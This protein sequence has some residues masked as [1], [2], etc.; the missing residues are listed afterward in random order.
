MTPQDEI[1]TDRAGGL[2][3]HFGVCGG[4][5]AQDVPYAAQAARKAAMLEAL[6]GECW[7]FPI[8]V[9]PSPAVWHYRN[10]VD[11]T[12]ARKRYDAPP[13]PDFVRETVLGFKQRGR[14]FA[15]LAIDECRIGPEGL[16]RLLAAVRGW[17]EARGLRAWDPRTGEGTLRA[18]LVR[19]G[20]R[21]GERM[22]VLLTRGESFD[23]ASFVRVVLDAFPATSVQHGVHR[24]AADGSLPETVEVLHGPPRIRERLIVPDEA[25]P[26]ELLFHISP[27]GF[28]QTNTLATELLYGKIRATVRAWRP[29]FLYDLYGGSGGIALACADLVERVYSV[30]SVAQA[31]LD[32]RDNA[33]ANGVANV[34]FITADTKRYLLDL[35]RSTGLPP[36]SAVVVDPPRAGLQAKVIKRLRALRAPLLVYVSCNP[37]QLAHELPDL[38]KVYRLHEVQAVD[39]FPHTPHVEV[40]AEF[41]LS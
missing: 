41:R 22:V 4:C 23:K 24:G 16:D 17:A 13:P 5:T 10:K 34:A 27:A 36:E 37:Q 20:K 30:E 29:R 3:P 8:P 32:G 12:F 14:W 35:E 7:P 6:F 31:T 40:V 9:T 25:A 18:L 38:L 11:P 33:R 26:R 19:E 15:P 39:L 2:C 1:G 28:F 21:T